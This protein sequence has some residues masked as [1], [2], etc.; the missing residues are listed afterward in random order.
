MDTRIREKAL[1]MQKKVGTRTAS[2]WNG[3]SGVAMWHP[4][5]AITALAAA[6]SDALR[7]AHPVTH[8]VIFQ[9]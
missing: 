4:A 5:T 1:W 9:H 8:L 6:F 3:P 7:L 2:S